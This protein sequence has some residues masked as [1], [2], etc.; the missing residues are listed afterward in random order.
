MFDIKESMFEV[1]NLYK[2]QSGIVSV[3]MNVDQWFCKYL[4]VKRR[5]QEGAPRKAIN[6]VSVH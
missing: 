2:K 3:C 1:P 6:R 4:Q 5:Q